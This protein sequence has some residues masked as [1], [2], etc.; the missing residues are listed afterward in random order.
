MSLIIN[1]ASSK[2]S[3]APRV[4]NATQ[5]LLNIYQYRIAPAVGAAAA[6]HAAITLPDSGTT[7]VTTQITNPD[8]P[9][10]LAITGN[11]ILIAG[12][13]VITGTDASGAIITDTIIANGVAQVVGTKAFA[14]V[15]SIVVP[16]RHAAGDTVT[17]DTLNVF[18][19]PNVISDANYLLLKLFNASTDAGSLAV[20]ATLSLNLYTIAGVP[21]GSKVLA[22][23]YLV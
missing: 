20:S 11:A 1:G 2:E 22:L 8:F 12:N 6:I 18:G 17:I 23:V 15:T 3:T 19:V 14:T 21:N 10:V 4:G 13:V 7:T 16:T 9:R 5:G